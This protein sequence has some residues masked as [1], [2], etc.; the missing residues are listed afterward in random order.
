MEEER[1]RRGGE[2]RVSFHVGVDPCCV[3]NELGS[4]S[5]P[6]GSTFVPFPF[7]FW[8]GNNQYYISSDGII[9]IL[10]AIVKETNSQ[11]DST[12]NH[13]PVVGINTTENTS[14]SEKRRERKR[15]EGL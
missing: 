11:L 15:Q 2:T 12:R 5:R 10:I 6:H 1:E 4:D 3:H 14:A 7:F 9:Y 13:F 8:I